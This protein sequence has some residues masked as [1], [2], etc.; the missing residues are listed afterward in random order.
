MQPLE[1]SFDLRRSPSTWS[2]HL[3]TSWTTSCPSTSGGLLARLLGLEV[4]A[5][6][7]VVEVRAHVHAAPCFEAPSP[8]PSDVMALLKSPLS[9]FAAAD[10]ELRPL[11][12]GGPEREVRLLI[13]TGWCRDGL[14]TEP[15]QLWQFTPW[16]CLVG[17]SPARL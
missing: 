16:D 6:Q 1:E 12:I 7:N 3:S 5:A 2:P 10:M 14:E 9:S 15:T 13:T 8:G 11:P 17:G 4:L